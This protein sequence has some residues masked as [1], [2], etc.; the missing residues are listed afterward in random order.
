MD[1]IQ[2]VPSENLVPGSILRVASLRFPG[3]K[4]WGVVDWEF[5]ENGQRKMWH[6]QK[7]D[8]LRSTNFAYFSSCQPV[9]IL[10]VPTAYEQQVWVIERLRSKEGLPWHLA[11]ANC[12]QVVRWAVEGTARSEQLNLG[13]GVALLAGA[14]LFVA[15]RSGE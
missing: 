13:V 4:H 3:V 9:E 7:S 14:L 1:P 12:E 8:V 10:W 6:S 11:T 2:F 5:D 15:T